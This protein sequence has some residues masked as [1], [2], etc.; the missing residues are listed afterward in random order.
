MKYLETIVKHFWKRWKGE[1]VTSLREYQKTFKPKNQLLPPKEDIVLIY[2]DKLPRQHWL[3]GK[4]ID[5]IPSEDGQIRG[6]KV[7]IGK[8]KNVIERPVNRLYPLETKYKFV[9]KNDEK[10]T[11]NNQRTK[12]KAA[13]LANVRIMNT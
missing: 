7:L 8:T 9:I 6:A 13:R 1:Y 11:M 4:I 3:L 12:R 2:D 10:I 5:L